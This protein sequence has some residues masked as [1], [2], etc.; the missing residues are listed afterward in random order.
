MANQDDIIIIKTVEN[1]TT[2]VLDYFLN[3][4][5]ITPIEEGDLLDEQ[6]FSPSGKEEYATLDAVAEKFKT[7]SK[8]YKIAR[9]V[10]AQK[11]NNGINQSNLKRLV[12][13]KK[14]GTDETYEKALTRIAYKNSY[15]VLINPTADEDVTSAYSWVGNYRKLLFAQTNSEDVVSDGEEDIASTLKKKNATRGV[16]YYHKDADEESLNGSLCSILASYPIGGKSA[17]YK[18]PTGIT[19]DELTDTEEGY[20]DSKNVNY[21]VPFIG[22]AGDYSTR[23]LTSANGVTLSGDEIEKIIAIDRTALSLQSA[24]MDGLEEDLPYDDNGGTILYSKVNSVYAELKNEGIFAEDSVDE[25]T[26]ETL[27]SYTIN[28]LPRATVK[29]NYPDY[30]AQK[31]FIIETTVQLAGSGKKVMITLAY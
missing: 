21:Y 19:V 23:Y 16:M 29:K 27:K 17:S 5:L 20:L 4:A 15:F 30:F 13:L 9:D 11:T 18:R 8:I 3:I 31:M 24:L 2:S 7:T 6:T 28:V 1:I 10:F 14:E 26:G 22:G 25:E 12:I